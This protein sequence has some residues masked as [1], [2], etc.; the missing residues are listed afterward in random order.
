M[1]TYEV[2]IRRLDAAT[3]QASARSFSVVL[4]GKR[5]D[6]TAGMN[7][8][9][10]LLSSLGACLLTSLAMVAELSHITMT[11]V[12][13]RVSATRQD[14]PPRL[15][16]ASYELFLQ[17][18][19]SQERAERLLQLAERNSTVFQTLSQSVSLSGKVTLGRSK[20]DHAPVKK[21]D[22]PS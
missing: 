13:I 11:E 19:V 2:C 1:Q 7:P 3:V 9:E 16:R 8:V 20:P 17:T 22:R 5:A 14:R 12:A 10:T 18:D 21:D 6:E 4:G 15:I